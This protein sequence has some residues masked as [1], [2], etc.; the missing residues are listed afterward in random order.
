MPLGSALSSA[1]HAAFSLWI[2]EK[3]SI[4]AMI[5]IP[6]AFVQQRLLL[7]NKRGILVGFQQKIK[8]AV[9]IR[10]VVIIILGPP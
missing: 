5:S 4:H 7:M 9:R 6:T 2:I 10:T 1:F 8:I 3:R